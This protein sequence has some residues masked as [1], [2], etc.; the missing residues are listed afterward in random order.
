M[1]RGP[2]LKSE[3]R[4][5]PAICK[6]T[7]RRVL[8]NLRFRS[9]DS[10]R[11]AHCAWRLFGGVATVICVQA[12]WTAWAGTPTD[13]AFRDASAS[14]RRGNYVEAAAAFRSLARVQPSTGVFRN[15]GNAEWQCGQVGEA[16][17]AWERAQWLD[18]YDGPSRTNLRFARKA[19]QIA[20]PDLAWYEVCSA[21]LPVD[22]WAWLSSAAFWL[23]AALVLLPD[24]FRWRKR[25]WH[26]ALATAGFALF[27]LTLPALAGVHFRS[28]LGVVCTKEAP[29]RLTPTREAQIVT[30]LPAGEMARVERQRGDYIYIR[31]G[32]DTAGWV[33][34]GEFG[35]V[36]KP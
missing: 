20:T 36:W 4:A 27:L 5:R 19:A 35:L 17:L 15:L 29:L 28:Q 21:W 30:R 13:T 32:N 18:P 24:I 10:R 33:R 22:A 11:L 2:T 25:E 34:R 3:S 1:S 12:S 14:Y 6:R 8:S 9:W 26:Q 16:V 23:T 31:A 7:G